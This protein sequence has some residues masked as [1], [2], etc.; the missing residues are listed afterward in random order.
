M[1]TDTPHHVAAREVAGL[2][3]LFSITQSPLFAPVLLPQCRGSFLLLLRNTFYMLL[4][5]A[6][7]WRNT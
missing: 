1:N 6:S 3:R 5:N 4:R 7:R 2:F